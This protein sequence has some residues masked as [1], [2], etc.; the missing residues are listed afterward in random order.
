[1]T[2]AAIGLA[3]A[4]LAGRGAPPRPPSTDVIATVTA[5][6]LR[7]HEDRTPSG[8]EALRALIERGVPPRALIVWLDHFRK[9]PRVDVIDI[10]LEVAQYRRTE[11]RARALVAWAEC[12]DAHAD[13][14][15]ALAAHDLDRGIRRLAITIARRHP[16]PAASVYLDELLGR[17]SVLADEVIHEAEAAG[18]R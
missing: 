9:A 8:A 4:M 7:M 3:L 2:F 11:I 15:I 16:S 1:M 10:L 14:A 18:S 17:D 6:L 5:R 12:G 13:R